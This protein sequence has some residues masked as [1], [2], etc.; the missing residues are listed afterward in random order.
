MVV[1][2]AQQGLQLPFAVQT[3]LTG[4]TQRHHNT[5]V[6]LN[7]PNPR[8]SLQGSLVSLRAETTKRRVGHDCFVCDV[9]VVKDKRRAPGWVHEEYCRGTDGLC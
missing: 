7:R 4:L 1:A 6:L 8:A 2:D 9:H 3:R 5:L